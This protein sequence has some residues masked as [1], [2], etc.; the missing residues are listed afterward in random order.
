MIC[1]TS[2]RATYADLVGL[3]TSIVSRSAIEDDSAKIFGMATA[4]T[5]S[6]VYELFQTEKTLVFLMI[7]FEKFAGSNQKNYVFIVLKLFRGWS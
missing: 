7:W 4:S 1:F 5:R 3:A 2:C 6:Q